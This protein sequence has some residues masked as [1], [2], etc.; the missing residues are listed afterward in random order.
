MANTQQWRLYAACRKADPDLF[1]PPDTAHGP[2]KMSNSQI[3]Q[4]LR[5]CQ[6]C[7]VAAECDAYAASVTDSLMVGVWGGRH[8]SQNDAESRRMTRKRAD[9]EV[10]S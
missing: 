3:N 10:A 9:E 5:Y 7:P 1:M 8:L 6:V 4:A 2:G